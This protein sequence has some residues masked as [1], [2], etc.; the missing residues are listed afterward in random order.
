MKS[1]AGTFLRIFGPIARVIPE[2]GKPDRDVA[3][4]EKAVYTVEEARDFLVER[5]GKLP[6]TPIILFLIRQDVLWYI[7][8]ILSKMLVR[9]LKGGLWVIGNLI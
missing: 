3:F 4:K 7:F 9:N 2:V 1:L 5:Y 8:I 6:K